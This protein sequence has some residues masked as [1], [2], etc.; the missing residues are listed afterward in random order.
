LTAVL[1]DETTVKGAL[2]VV[3]MLGVIW[4]MY[5]GYVWLTNAVQTDRAE[6]RMLL[7]GGMGAFLIVALAVPRAFDSGGPAFGIAYFLVVGVHLSLFAKTS[8]SDTLRAVV[9]LAPFN[10]ATAALVLAGGIAG[11]TAQYVLWALAFALEWLTP[12]VLRSGFTIAAGHFVERHGLVILIA[13]GESIIAVGV[14][15]AE[16]PLDVEL[17]AVALLALA[18]SACLWW[19]YFGTGDDARAEHALAA[20]APEDR[21]RLAVEAFG[22]WHLLMLLGIIGL[23]AAEKKVVAH[24]LDALATAQAVTLGAAAAVFLLGDVLFRRSLGITRGAT[25]AAAIVLALSTIPL[26]LAAAALQLSAL[27]AALAAALA[28]ERRAPRLTRAR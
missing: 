28:S 13:I 25:R 18:C 11:G 12:R 6:R 22:Y 8:D 7:L 26:G 17:A 2:Q 20:A 10:L 23:A 5:S 15:A 9:A 27:V 4:W 19:A 14:G 1:A 24:P 21:P 3:L 16:A